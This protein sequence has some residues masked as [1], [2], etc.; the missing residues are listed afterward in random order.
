LSVIDFKNGKST[1]TEPEDP[2][3]EVSSYIFVVKDKV[4]GERREYIKTGHLIVTAVNFAL[5]S[6][7]SDLIWAVANDL[8][9]IS[10]ER[11]ETTEI[12][13]DTQEFEIR[14]PVVDA[15]SEA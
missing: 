14:T 11:I 4:S 10:V 13:F 15:P 8:D 7:D 12:V 5:L 6:E 1:P 3:L 2:K 9:F